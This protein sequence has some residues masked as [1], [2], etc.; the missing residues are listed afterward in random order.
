M[1]DSVDRF[2]FMPTAQVSIVNGDFITKPS[3][4]GPSRSTTSNVSVLEYM[5]IHVLMY[6]NTHI[7]THTQAQVRVIP[8]AQVISVGERRPVPWW[9]IVVPIAVAIIFIV[10]VAVLLW[11]VSLLC[12]VLRLISVTLC[13]TM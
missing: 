10:I 8:A 13:Y 3:D 2:V 9:A 7:I 6:I 1:Q 5:L 11:V 12:I 4:D